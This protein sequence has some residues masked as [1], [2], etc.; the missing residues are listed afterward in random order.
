MATDLVN[1]SEYKA[2]AGINST[3]QDDTIKSLIPKVSSL[4]KSLCRRSFVDYVDD[5][6]V[7]VYQGGRGSRL[8]L[9][10]YPIISI[11]SFEYSG[12]Y[13]A[14]YTELTEFKDYVLDQEDGSLINLITDNWPKLVN[15][16]KITYTAGY[17]T[18][19]QDLKLAIFD[20]ITYYLRHDTAVH[21]TR[22][23]GSN[24][25]QIEYITNVALPAHITRILNL[26]TGSFD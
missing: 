23:V 11:Q 9:K 21:S 13:G 6:K 5:T 26:Y 12:D 22:N 16:Y 8:Y 18:L 2:Y 17:E 19:P 14:T 24:T 1:I 4:I 15:G 20:T 25:V 7:E 3:N 10:E